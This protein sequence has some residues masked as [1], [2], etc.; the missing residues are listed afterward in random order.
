MTHESPQQ[1]AALT[2]EERLHKE[3]R[4][5]SQERRELLAERQRLQEINKLL[6]ASLGDAAEAATGIIEQLQ[7]QVRALERARE[8]LQTLAD[9][10]NGPPLPK[11]EEA[12]NK[13]ME[14]IRAY[15]AST[16]H[17]ENEHE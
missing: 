5:L 10:Q 4:G 7:A 13:A 9:L 12:W 15:L 17:V 3:L 6:R 14:D 11:Y 8:L 2:N 16:E 1:R